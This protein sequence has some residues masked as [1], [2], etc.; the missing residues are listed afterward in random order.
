MQMLTV[1]TPMVVL[2]VLVNLVM[3]AME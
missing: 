3:K 1:P 2:P